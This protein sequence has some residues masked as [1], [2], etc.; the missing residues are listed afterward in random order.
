[1][2]LAWGVFGGLLVLVWLWRGLEVAFGMR[3][4]AELTEPQW[5]QYPSSRITI[6]VPAKDEAESIEQCLSSLLALEYDK[7]EIVAI[8]DRSGDRTGE[9]MDRLAVQ[10]PDRLKVIHVKE[11][12]SQWLG[13]TH[14]MW[15]GAKAASG[16]WILFTDGDVLFHPDSLRR[17]VGYAEETGADHLV[18]FPTL[19]MNG[20]G[21]RMMLSSFQAMFTLWQRPWKVPDP[22]SRDYV[23]AGAFSLIRRGAYQQIGTYQSLRL[24]VLDDMMLGKAV[25]DC[26]LTQH[27][28]FGRDLI[29]LRWAKGAFG[30]V[31]N[32]TKN[33]FSLLQ[34]NWLRALAAACVLLIFN[35]GIPVGIVLAPGVAK[36]GFVVAFAIIAALYWGMSKR[37][38]LS[39]G[40]SFFIP[41]RPRSSSSPYFGRR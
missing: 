25:K 36:I 39:P 30:I 20:P 7:Y 3:R 27:C 38:D 13:K 9:I 6:V 34:F 2:S 40:T 11:I 31:N 14:A 12:P 41:S 35:L 23:G 32:L 22:K 18:L 26:G 8:D 37:V 16:D 15:K 4:V 5:N 24:E 28:V 17:A 21:E 19:I 10:Y 29:R 33:L 1:M